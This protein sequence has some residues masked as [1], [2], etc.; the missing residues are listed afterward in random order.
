MYTKKLIVLTA[1]LAV[2]LSGCSRTAP[3]NNP[4]AEAQAPV[5]TEPAELV[6][7]YPFPQDWDQDKFTKTFSEPL[8]KKHPHLTVKYI[9]G[10]S[11]GTSIPELITAGQQIDIVA[12]S[13]GV[14]PANLLDAGLQYDITPLIK[15]FKYDLA[16]IDPSMV[17]L[18][19]QMADGGMYGLPVLVP[20][21]TIYYNKDL[22][23]RFGIPYPSNSMT[24]DDLIDLNKK[25][26][27]QDNGTQ[28]FGF[29]TSYNHYLLLNQ[30][31]IPLVDK[32]TKT[33]TFTSDDRWKPFADNFLRLYS[34]SA[35]ASLQGNQMSEPYERNQ[36]F[37]DR[38][39]AMFLA[40]TALEPAERLEGMNWDL[41]PYPVFKDKPELG[42]QAYPTYFYITTTSEHKDQAFQALTFWTSDEFQQDNAKKGYFVPISSNPE[43]MKA[44]GQ[45]NPLYKGKNVMA[46]RPK[47][48]AP[49]GDVTKYDNAASRVP[50]LKSVIQGKKDI[51]TV[52]REATESVNKTIEQQEAASK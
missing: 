11:K 22:F 33:A 17:D 41:A 40:H 9:V 6:V 2:V 42:P 3:A 38:T 12:S 18:A 1:L 15:K 36:F 16:K 48:Y 45:E 8:T 27:R 5:N 43:V 24:W 46:L 30:W 25:L 4:E 14:T 32:K 19:K 26:T 7:Y 34:P 13:I 52:L 39:F 44:F 37:K 31:S 10:G 28:Y 20:P 51:N 49:A 23:D 21:A 47:K 35:Y 29:G 50:D